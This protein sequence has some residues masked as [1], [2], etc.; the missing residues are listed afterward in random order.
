MVADVWVTP[1]QPRLARSSTAQTSDRQ[2]VSPGSRPMTL[3]RR[4][5][6][7]K[8]RSIV[9]V[10][11][12]FPVLAWEAQVHGERGEVVL[13][14]GDRR[15]VELAVAGGEAAGTA[16]RPVRREPAPRCR[17]STRTPP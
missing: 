15:G 12:A 14:A 5:D 17:R 1:R 9:G 16:R 4:R 6:S 3:T 10:A 13:Q 2:V 8:V 11:D 7:P